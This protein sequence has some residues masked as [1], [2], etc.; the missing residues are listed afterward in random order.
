MSVMDTFNGALTLNQRMLEGMRESPQVVRRGLLVV[1][2]VGLLV[3]GV[4]GL[5]T[6][7]AVLDPARTVAP[8][9]AAL[10]Q[11]SDQIVTQIADPA[12]QALVRGLLELPVA[13]LSSAERVAELPTPLPR[14]VGA[15]TSGLSV[16]V[17]TPVSYLGGLLLA[18]IL[19]HI[20]A[21][22]FGGQGSLQQM[23]G[24]GA[25]S[26]AP[27]AL[28][29]LS[30][31]PIL[32]STLGL[33]AWGWGLVILIAAV[34]TAHRLNSGRATLAV[35]LYPLILALLGIVAYCGLV[36]FSVALLSGVG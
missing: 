34:S 35:L 11:Q 8:Q 12:G 10:K 6:M 15:L 20:A 3:G 2:L 25:L 28:D 5:R 9:Q 29:A 17:T 36:F 24:L 30:F 1:V 19:A 13:L 31:V 33:V 22:Q 7:L 26:V 4:D 18:I 23:L 21:R 27:H 16:L 32:G 14:A